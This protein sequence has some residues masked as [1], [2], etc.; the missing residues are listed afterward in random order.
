MYWISFGETARG[1]DL[2]EINRSRTHTIY[3]NTPYQMCNG[4]RPYFIC[5][6][7]H[8]IVY[9]YYSFIVT[10]NLINSIDSYAAHTFSPGKHIGI[11]TDIEANK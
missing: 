5:A 3:Y 9:L 4:A 10:N 2:V 11:R 1:D 6:V 7:I 8:I